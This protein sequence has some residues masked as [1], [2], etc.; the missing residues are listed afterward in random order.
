VGFDDT[1]HASLDDFAERQDIEI[2]DE[3]PMMAVRDVVVFNYMIIPLFVGRNSS[4][5]AVN[6]ALTK[7]KLLVLLTQRD[8]TQED[9]KP[10]E[11]YDVGMVSMIM[12]TLKLPDGRLKVLVQALSKAKIK[13]YIQ[14]EPFFLVNPEVI[15]EQEP[16]KITVEI[17]ALM[18]TVREQTEK[19]MSLRGILSSDLVM[20]MNNIEEPG[21]LADL[22]GSNLRLK[23]PEAQSVLECFDSVERL[24]LV[25]DYLN[26]ELEVSTMQAKIQT[27]AKE[28]MSRSQREYYLREQL[29]ALKK[30]LGD[31]DDRAQ[32]MEELRVKIIKARM[33]PHAKK[34]AEKQL[35]RL[36]MMHPDAS[37]AGIIRT[38]LDWLVEVPWRKGSRDRLDLKIA[39]QVLDKDHYG[40]DKVKERILEYLAV[41]KLNKSTK[42]PILCFVGPPGV[43]KTSL[44]QSIARALGR[45]F[46]RV[47]LGGMRDEAEIRGH[48][49]TYIGALPGRI[50]QGLKTVGAN[51]PVFMMDE[52]DKVGSDYRG[53]PSSALLEVLDPEQNFSFSD[54]YLNLP[55]D[56]SKVMFITTANLMDTIPSPLLD[57]MEIIRLAGYTLEEKL[58]IANRYLLPRQLKENGIKEKHIKLDDATLKRI[59]SHYTRESGL[60]NLERAIGKVCRKIARRIAEGGKGPYTISQRTLSKYLG[61][62]RFLPE[63]EQEAID[64]PGL[65]TGLAWT[66]TGGEIL[67]IET[68]I[69]KGRGNLILTGQLGDVMKESAKAALSFCRSRMDKLKLSENYFEEVDI[70]IH[71]PAGAIPKDGP[72]AG[73]TMATSL[74]SALSKQTVT[75]G[76]A[77]TGE[78]TLRGR[79]LPIGGLKEKALAALR[80]GINRII[81]P[82]Y[83]KK[84]LV[85]I[86][87]DIRAQME[88]IPVKNMDKILKVAF[89]EK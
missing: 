18:R 13:K 84:D 38:Y 48:R 14:E 11:L 17:E 57:R 73:V 79:V 20:I 39:K 76:L 71:V 37:E 27:E 44:G 42:G 75:K 12:R 26:K 30:E 62:P 55:Y 69:M 15:D 43:G 50:I 25:G 77:M 23:I 89:K 52:I 31:V 88:F 32:E 8:A 80:A 59:I 58:E 61:P 10:E 1:L 24:K 72:S 21:R 6:E 70:H 60:R 45:K 68:I 33:P 4:V 28:E 85:E 54:H 40:L 74:Y 56:L 51:N 87:K 65:V 53:D 67:Y 22:V 34:E 7:D 5:A 83:N 66:E 3:L 64:Q 36:E 19:I 63:A 9:P 82:D 2:P 46:H 47:S 49:R 41:R 86:P 81:I 35:K 16:G 29:Q 78:I